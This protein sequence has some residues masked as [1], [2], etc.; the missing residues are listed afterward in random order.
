MWKLSQHNLGWKGE[1]SILL[2]TLTPKKPSQF[3][4]TESWSISSIVKPQKSTMILTWNRVRWLNLKNRFAELRRALGPWFS[5]LLQRAETVLSLKAKTTISS[6]GWLSVQTPRSERSRR[7]KDK[8]SRSSKYSWVQ[9]N[10]SEGN[11]MKNELLA[12][13]MINSFNGFS[14]SFIFYLNCTNNWFSNIFW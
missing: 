3:H 13:L 8:K 4:K 9:A 14:F 6:R 11:T 2:K 1:N 7:S 12:N 5:K 10:S